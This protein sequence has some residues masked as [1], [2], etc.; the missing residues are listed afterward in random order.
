LHRHASFDENFQLEGSPSASYGGAA[1]A[2]MDGGADS[3]F[4]SKRIVDE[5]EEDKD[6]N[7]IAAQKTNMSLNKFL[8]FCKGHKVSHS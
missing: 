1:V 8:N 2:P 6:E 4:M 5:Y 7:L 3:T